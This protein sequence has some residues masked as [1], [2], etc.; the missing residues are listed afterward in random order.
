MT[1]TVQ[2]AAGTEITIPENRPLPPM[3]GLIPAGVTINVSVPSRKES[4]TAQVERD[5]SE[6]KAL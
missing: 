4:W 5:K 6:A 3:E 2:N 1:D